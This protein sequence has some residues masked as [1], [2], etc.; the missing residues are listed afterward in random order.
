MISGSSGDFGNDNIEY[1]WDTAG[2]EDID[3]YRSH[4]G[5]LAGELGTDIHMYHDAPTWANP[6]Y[7]HAAIAMEIHTQYP[8]GA[9]AR[10]W[11]DT[12]AEVL[13]RDADHLP[14]GFGY[15]LSAETNPIG[16]LLL[17]EFEG[18][19]V[20]HLLEDNPKAMKDV[21]ITL[22]RLR[23]EAYLHI[24]WGVVARHVFGITNTAEIERFSLAITEACN[25]SPFR[26]I[27][28]KLLHKKR[29]GHFIDV[30]I[31]YT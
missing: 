31:L 27:P 10:V 17:S 6:R 2:V 22:V 3:E 4:L 29:T 5:E 19:I 25:A 8:D 16:H 9:S 20:G 7:F 12:L 15:A 24:Q 30:G 1:D 23:G 21:G 14:I 11:A 26:A 28:A 13:R 18:R